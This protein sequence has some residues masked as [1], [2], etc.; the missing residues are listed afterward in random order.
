[1]CRWE[2]EEMLLFKMV[3]TTSDVARNALHETGTTIMRDLRVWTLAGVFGKDSEHDV[4]YLVVS[5]AA[6]SRPRYR[7]RISLTSNTMP[8]NYSSW[9][10]CFWMRC[11]TKNSRMKCVDWWWPFCRGSLFK[12]L[13]APASCSLLDTQ[14]ELNHLAIVLAL[15]FFNWYTRSEVLGILVYDGVHRGETVV[16]LLD[17][18][19]SFLIW[20]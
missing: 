2:M 9:L 16:C 1:M 4:V 11:A 5:P 14:A 6:W 12:E 20:P 18:G 10:V 19:L 17:V 3:F 7:T 15:C 13:F 8:P